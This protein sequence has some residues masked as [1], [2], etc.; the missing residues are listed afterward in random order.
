M[1]GSGTF[2][3][4]AALALLHWK[5]N[6]HRDEFA[7]MDLCQDKAKEMKA[8]LREL[9][10]KIIANEKPLADLPMRIK[11]Y[12]QKNNIEVFDNMLTPLRASDIHG[13][14]IEAAKECA[15]Q[16]GVAKVI[17]FSTNDVF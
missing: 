1:C 11:L 15:K 2:A 17:S 5:P 3:I 14:N 9:K 16:A 13:S 4:E 6:V 10:A 12:A 8:A 7:F